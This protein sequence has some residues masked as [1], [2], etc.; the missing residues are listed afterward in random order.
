MLLSKQ[1]SKKKQRNRHSCSPHQ[2]IPWLFM[3]KSDGHV[4]ANSNLISVD[5]TAATS[6]A[7]TVCSLN[8]MQKTHGAPLTCKCCGKCAKRC[9]T[10]EYHHDD[11]SSHRPLSRSWLTSQRWWP[12]G[13]CRCKS[14]MV[15]FT[16]WLTITCENCEGQE[17]QK[18]EML[19]QSNQAWLEKSLAP[20]ASALSLGLRANKKCTAS[21]PQ[22]QPT[23]T[24]PVPIAMNCL[25]CFFHPACYSSAGLCREP[26]LSHRRSFRTVRCWNARPEIKQNHYQSNTIVLF[27]SEWDLACGGS[28]V[29]YCCCSSLLASVGFLMFV[30]HGESMTSVVALLLSSA[31][32]HKKKKLLRHCDWVVYLTLAR[33]VHSA[34]TLVALRAKPKASRWTFVKN[35]SKRGFE[36]EP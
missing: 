19:V 32:V 17:R 16:V 28:W 12:R 9:S 33:L 13:R 14:N 36:I 35:I 15:P 31:W 21:P 4:L 10:A 24:D 34:D 27:T 2:N 7:S 11:F 26:W 23:F 22:S 8:D 29:K 5:A 1:N 18:K 25:S 6:T 30:L 3:C 20:H